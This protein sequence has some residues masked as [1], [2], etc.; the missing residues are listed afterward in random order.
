MIN[1]K[2]KI[3]FILLTVLVF[4]GIAYYAYR[5]V[6]NFRLD[7]SDNEATTTGKHT[8]EISPGIFVEVEGDAIPTI[9]KVPINDKLIVPPDLNRPINISS[10]TDFQSGQK[11]VNQIQNLSSSLKADP[12]SYDNW[13]DLGIYRK[14]LN[15]YKGAEEIWVYLT[16][17]A[18]RVAT[19]YVNLGDLYTYYFHDNKKAEVN[20]LKAAELS[21]R[22]SEVYSRTVDFYIL[23][24][25]DPAK[26]KKFLEDG[27]AK[28]PDMKIYLEPMLK[29]LK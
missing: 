21:P 19:A 4:S 24:L 27:I 8:I 5:E 25:N 6:L 2:N 20:F 12:N 17:S 1:T 16:K 18:P 28:Y 22:W 26:A 10:T 13:L 23:A 11:L 7:G 3:L 14:M 15:D 9:T 29:Q